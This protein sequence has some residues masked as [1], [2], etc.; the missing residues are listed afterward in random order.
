MIIP[1]F[2]SVEATLLANLHFF[3][4][5]SFFWSFMNSAILATI[6]LILW[7]FLADGVYIFLEKC[8]WL[9]RWPWLKEW[10]IKKRG[11]EDPWVKC[12]YHYRYPGLFF[13]GAAPLIGL[14]AQKIF[15]FKYGYLVLF[16]GNISKILL[17]VGLIKFFN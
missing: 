3:E 17:I 12:I 4:N 5:L 16:A 10:L 14:P 1:A 6:S 13:G 2:F 11:K 8:P 15:Q 7:C 9:K